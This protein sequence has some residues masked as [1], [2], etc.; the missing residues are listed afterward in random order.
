MSRTPFRV[1]LHSIV[2]WM[3]RNS[4]LEAGANIWME[5]Y[6]KST[7]S[8][9]YVPFTSNYPQHSLTNISF[10]LARRT[11]TI[12]KN[13]NVKEKHSKELKRTLLEQKYPKS[14]IEATILRAKEIP[15]E[16]FRQPKIAKNEEIILFTFTYNLNNPNVFS[17]IK[18]SFDTISTCSTFFRGRNWS[19]LW[20]KHL[21]LV[22]YYV[23]LNLNHSTKLTKWNIVERI[24]SGA[25]IF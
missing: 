3:S 19:N 24:A 13:E 17:I 9:R 16:I 18:Q 4:L 20:A 5:I 25:L 22:G 1:N 11:C 2:A 14:L 23:G 7:D 21:I 12:V 15:L 6:N 10:S 8:K